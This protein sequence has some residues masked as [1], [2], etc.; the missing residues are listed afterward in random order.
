M[1]VPAACLLLEACI[2]PPV[3]QPIAQTVLLS[4]LVRCCHAYASGPQGQDE[5]SGK[6]DSSTHSA[7]FDLELSSRGR[8]AAADLLARLNGS[9]HDE[10]SAHGG[11]GSGDPSVRLPSGLVQRIVYLGRPVME[12]ELDVS[13]PPRTHQAAAGSAHS[14]LLGM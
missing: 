4:A 8:G 11:A 3:Q 14:L 5:P 9:V 7:L 13:A 10:G 2:S 12:F 6:G 1:S